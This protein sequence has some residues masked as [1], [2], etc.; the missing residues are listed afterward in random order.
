MS[1]YDDDTGKTKKNGSKKSGAGVF[2]GWCISSS[3]LTLIIG[4]IAI[5]ALVLSI[6]AFLRTNNGDCPIVCTNGTDGINGTNGINGTCIP[7]VNGSGFIDFADF[8][9]LMPGDNA[10]TISIGGDVE[11]PQIGPA[12]IGTGITSFSATQI[13]LALNGTYEIS[14]F[15]SINEAAQLELTLN[16]VPITNTVTGRATGTN[17]VITNLLITVPTALSLLT[18]RNPLG[19]PSALTCTP[20]A[21]GTNSVSAHLKIVQFA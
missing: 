11:F 15:V 9:A 19:N 5:T 21:G 1:S 17:Y 3:L 12:R 4:A 16:G 13:Q 18:V 6:I 20:I 14:F 10:A 8:Y 7:C 2:L